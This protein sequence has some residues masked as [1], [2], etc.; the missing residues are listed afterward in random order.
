MESSNVFRIGEYRRN[1]SLVFLRIRHTDRLLVKGAI[2]K[3]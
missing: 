1:D 3:R 2:V